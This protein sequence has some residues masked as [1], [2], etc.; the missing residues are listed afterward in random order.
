MNRQRHSRRDDRYRSDIHTEAVQAALAKHKSKRVPVLPIPVKRRSLMVHGVI[1][2]VGD[3]S[4]DDMGTDISTG[5][6]GSL[7]RRTDGSSSQ[8]SESTTPSPASVP[9]VISQKTQL[10]KGPQSIKRT[11]SNSKNL[12]SSDGMSSGERKRKTNPHQPPT[13]LTK[14][15]ADIM[16]QILPGSRPLSQNIP[17]D[18]A[19]ISVSNTV[20]SSISAPAVSSMEIA[21]QREKKSLSSRPSLS[22]IDNESEENIAVTKVSAKI[23]QLLLTLKADNQSSVNEDPTYQPSHQ[24]PKKKPLVE[25]FQDEQEELL[26]NTPVDENA[27]KPEGTVTAPREGGPLP[28][29]T[30]TPHSIEAAIH[31]CGTANPKAPCI[32]SVDRNGKTAYTLMYGKL[33]SRMRK[34]AY[35]LTGK[36]Y[37][38]KPGQ[39]IALVFPNSEPVPFTCAFYGCLLAGLIPVV[40]EVPMSSDD[41]GSPQLG[42][43][44]GSCAVNVALTCDQCLK[45]LPK[46]EKGE[47]NQLKGWPKLQWILTD[48]R[49]MAKPSSSWEPAGHDPANQVAFIEYK[50]GKEGSVMGVAHSRTTIHRHC[51]ALVGAL[52]YNAGDIMVNLLDFK[53]GLGLVHGILV[54]IFSGMH[55]YCIPYALMKQNPV[56]WLNIITK[57]KASIALVKSRDLHWTL[58]M[59]RET[60]NVNL[61]TLRMLV[62]SDGANP[63]S[64]GSC[65]MFL[66][67]FERRGLN[68]DAICPCAW[69]PEALTV[70][71]RRPGTLA[72]RTALSLHDMSYNVIHEETPTSQTPSVVLQDCGNILPGCTA[73]IV[74]VDGEPSLCRTD[75]VGEILL[76]TKPSDSL[77]SGSWY[78]GLKGIS[79]KVFH[80]HPIDE[81]NQQVEVASYIRTGLLGYVDP[82]GRVLVTG[83]TE[84]LLHISGRYHNAD[85]IVATVLAIEPIRFVYRGRIAV[86]GIPVLRDEKLVVIVEQKPDCEEQLCFKWMSSVIQ[87]VEGIHNVGVYCLSLLGPNGLPRTPLGGVHLSESR[88]RFLDGNLEPRNILMSPHQCVLN[89]PKPREKHKDVGAASILQGQVVTG[90]RLAEAKGRQMAPLMDE[91]EAADKTRKFQYLS[92]ILKWRAQST[93]D[94]AL[95]SQIGSKVSVS[96]QLTCLQLHRKAEKI[97]QL[98]LSHTAQQGSTS[99]TTGDRVALLFQPGVEL[100]TAFYGCLY[101]GCV[102]VPVRPPNIKSLAATLPTVRMVIE[103]SKAVAI[104]STAAI[105]KTLRSKEAATLTQNTSTAN[106]PPLLDLD[107][108]PRKKVGINYRPPTPEMLAYIDFSVTAS[109]TLAGIKMSHY[110]SSQLCRS[111]KLQCELYPSRT[112]AI[113]LD[114]YSGLGLALWC[115][116]SVFSGH[117]SLLIAPSELEL[118]PQLWLHAVS[119]YKIRDTFLSYGVVELC[120]KDIASH[121]PTLKNRGVSLNQVRTCVIVAEERPRVLLTSNF[122]KLFRDLGLSSRAVSTAFGCR[123]NIAVCLQGASCPDPTTVYVDMR[124]LRNDRVALVEKGSPQ[125]LCLMETGKILP[126]TKVVIADPDTLGQ[127]SDS[128]LGEVWVSSSHTAHGYYAVY[129]GGANANYEEHFKGQLRTGD[130]RTVY[131]RTGFLGF[132]RRTDLTSA[133]GER[134]DALYIVGSLEETL[135]LRGMRYHPIDIENSVVRCSSKI[136]ECAVFHSTNLLVVVIELDGN[137]RSALDLVPLVT[138]IILEEHYLIAGVVA[139]TDPGSIPANSRGEKQRMHLRDAFLQDKLDP[140]YVA[141]NM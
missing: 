127:C 59:Q 135:E 111:M 69:S 2:S 113:C 15:L 22:S 73:A 108:A 3:S 16:P 53:K 94:H 110:S 78:Y 54:S 141:Y 45:G 1:N 79:E 126:G 106:W 32:T 24:R 13:P 75:E 71:I 72:A 5:D 83:K 91:E 130:T 12:S 140:I 119:Q 81:S 29:Q 37:Q 92:E 70:A 104:L 74:K 117:Q 99:L 58:A 137:E 56:Q 57:N 95:F 139:I 19:N 60:M 115:L 6:D 98:L 123:V 86:F 66:G 35:T 128:R 65:D 28:Q 112:V 133:T 76:C 136:A 97:A 88:T 138:N 85:D 14:K 33:L 96:N 55:V 23:Q 105:I 87:A 122:T 114:P 49:N 109:G 67:E 89:L 46:N 31:R 40:V 68:R 132:L 7:Q 103:I 129:G 34:I 121:I 82:S 77:D 62:V 61:K 52:S 125:S 21:D 116:S 36:R 47:V 26:E 9:R 124:S 42:F 134:H 10:P 27:P 11:A 63:W 38:L 18:V 102:P 93:P 39:R 50:T 8:S 43:L 4:D 80:A 84:G 90:V 100:I 30:N 64:I 131:A 48:T 120:T 101:A 107:E 118:N 44:L 17:P 51:R 25:Y 41:P 20:A